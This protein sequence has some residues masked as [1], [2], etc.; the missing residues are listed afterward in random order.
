MRENITERGGHTDT[1]THDTDTHTHTHDTHAQT[2]RT[3]H[4]NVPAVVISVVSMR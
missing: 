2:T 4:A 3:I 1:D